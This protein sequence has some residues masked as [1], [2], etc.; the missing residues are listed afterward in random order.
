MKKKKG[1]KKTQYDK[2]N[3][4]PSSCITL[5]AIM[6]LIKLRIVKFYTNLLYTV[7]RFYVFLIVLLPNFYNEDML[8]SI[9]WSK[10]GDIWTSL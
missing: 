1:R 3:D 6:L 4:K 7:V 2:Q 9:F 10:C 5:L 8:S